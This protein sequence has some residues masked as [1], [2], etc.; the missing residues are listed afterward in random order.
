MDGLAH[1]SFLELRLGMLIQVPRA[2]L[3]V[4]E[5]VVPRLKFNISCVNN[6]HYAPIIAGALSDDAVW[7][8]SSWRLSVCL[9]HTSGLS[10]EQR[11]QGRLKLAQ[12]HQAALVGC[13]S[14]Y[15]I[16]VDDTII[17]TRASRCLSIMNI[18]GARRAGRR[19]CK[20]SMGWSWAAACGVQGRGHFSR[21]PAQPGMSLPP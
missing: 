21:L 20:A 18:H 7:H 9:L 5:R 15:I 13:S 14:H 8:L 16:Y 17:I 3:P 1:L 10:R 2:V 12:G 11:G 6:H 19:R 4:E